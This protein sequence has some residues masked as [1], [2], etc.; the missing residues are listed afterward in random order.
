M[1]VAEDDGAPS[2][3]SLSVKNMRDSN[4]F[5]WIST[6]PW[7]WVAV[8]SAIDVRSAGNAGQGPSSTLGT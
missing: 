7:H 5:S 2:A 6:V 3:T 4:I 8:T 1:R